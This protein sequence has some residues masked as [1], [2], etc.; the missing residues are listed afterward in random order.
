MK[1]HFCLLLTL[2]L[3][4]TLSSCRTEADKMAEFCLSFEQITQNTED[5]TQMATQLDTFLQSPHPKLKDDQICAN[6]TACLPCRQAVRK[7]L[8][9][10]G[11]APEMR[12]VLDKMTFSKT[13]RTDL[14]ST[15]NEN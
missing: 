13:L 15:Q 11:H 10:C 7:L 14:P 8:Q 9:T 1:T 2:L 12:P 4:A 5:C 6:S 3:A